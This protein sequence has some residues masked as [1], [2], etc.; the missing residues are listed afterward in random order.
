MVWKRSATPKPET[1]SRAILFT[2]GQSSCVPC[3]CL[4]APSQTA[5]QTP[6]PPPT[7]SQEIAPAFEMPRRSA[8]I[9][10]TG[11][12]SEAMAGTSECQKGLST[13]AEGV[14]GLGVP[15][16]TASGIFCHVGKSSRKTS[17]IAPK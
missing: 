5:D 7:S 3:A 11:N 17:A 6:E 9:C 13:T 12:E 8:A 14:Q 10:A 2:L 15:L 1:N 4:F 16:F